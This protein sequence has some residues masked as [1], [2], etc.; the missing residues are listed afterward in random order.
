MQ[1]VL[2][3]PERAVSPLLRIEGQ[4]GSEIA[5][6]A[7]DPSGTRLYFSSQRGSGDGGITYEVTGPFRVPATT[8]TTT[9]GP[10]TTLS[11][12]GGEA[13]GDGDDGGLPVAVPVGAAAV[14]AALMGAL[15]WR[16]RGARA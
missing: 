13:G 7:F 3:T 9:P 10:T 11:G 6:P 1:L 8:T 14:V 4:D 12:L 5:G 2:I 16:R 15:A